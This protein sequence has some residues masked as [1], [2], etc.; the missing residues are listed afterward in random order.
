[1]AHTSSDLAS[2]A[3]EIVGVANERLWDAITPENCLGMA[4]VALLQC[5][6]KVASEA[7]ITDATA[8]AIVALWNASGLTY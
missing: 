5:I 8:P 7:G 6:Q 4:Q 1:M 3:A 2:F